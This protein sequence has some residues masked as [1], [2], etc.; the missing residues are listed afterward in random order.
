L[1]TGEIV[2]IAAERPWPG[3]RWRHDLAVGFVPVDKTTG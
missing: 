1:A 3:M 2:S